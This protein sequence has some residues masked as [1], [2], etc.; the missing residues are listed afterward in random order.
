MEHLPLAD[1][2]EVMEGR[3]RMHGSV[4]ERIS[5]SIFNFLLPSLYLTES[6][7]ISNELCRVLNFF[8][9]NIAATCPECVFSYAKE[10]VQ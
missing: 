4:R 7:N 8:D 5:V 9:F 6:G 3:D 10:T 2:K 1:E